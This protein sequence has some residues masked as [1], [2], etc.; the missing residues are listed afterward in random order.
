MNDYCCK[1]EIDSREQHLDQLN[2]EYKKLKEKYQ[3]LLIENVQKDVVLRELKQKIEKYKYS[4]FEGIFDHS[5]LEKLRNFGDAKNDDSKF[6]ECAMK[7]LY[8]GD[9]QALQQKTLSGRSRKQVAKTAIS[10]EKKKILQSL[11][12]ERMSYLT[13]DDLRKKNLNS[14]IRN[15]IDSATKNENKKAMK[16]LKE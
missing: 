11:Y 3:K 10:P 2:S 12:C 13:A 1:D 8:H 15:T 7:N 14:L 9:M 5:C 6:I 16:M 4:T